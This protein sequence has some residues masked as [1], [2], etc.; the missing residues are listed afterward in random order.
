MNLK[1]S[2]ATFVLG[3]VFLA[4]P[5]CADDAGDSADEAAA[6][7]T[8]ATQDELTA[9]AAKLVGAFH[10]T[11]DGTAPAPTFEG[12]VFQQNGE[13]FADVDTGIR[14]ITTPC[15]SN[16][17]LEGRFSATKNYLRLNPNPGQQATEAFGRY[18]YT[19]TNDGKLSL[20]RTTAGSHHWHGELEKASSYCAAPTDCEE[21]ALIHPMCVGHWTCGDQRT[22]GY[23]CGV[24]VPT[25]SIWPAD[26]T[27]L[28]AINQGGGFVPPPPAGSECGFGRAKYT[29]DIET[30]TL[31]SETCAA[32]ASGGPLQ[33][34]T[35]S[36][37]ITTS[38][39]AKIDAAMKKVK[40]TTKDFCGTD[41]QSLSIEVTSTS[42]GPKSYFDSFYACSGGGRTYVDNIDGVFGAF[43]ALVK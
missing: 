30:L 40:V 28:V 18:R 2:V 36:R 7:E 8:A 21:Q 1:V 29:L 27:K 5:G 13:F 43:R 19:L 15:P 39:L 42:Q 25:N 35:K 24:I 33:I 37:T 41:K 3:S 14:C 16:A 34:A 31:S 22:C 12:I 6:E 32:P 20:T 26:K 11:S 10:G 38:E 4:I 17:R 23:A 9:N